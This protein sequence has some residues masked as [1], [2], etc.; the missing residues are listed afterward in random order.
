MR[1]GEKSPCDDVINDSGVGLSL[2]KS[3]A[4]NT[5][6]AAPKT[7]ARHRRKRGDTIRASDFVPPAG[8]LAS[9]A[10]ASV[11]P[12]ITRNSRAIGRTR[13]GTVTLASNSTHLSTASMASGSSKG[14]EDL[15]IKVREEMLKHKRRHKGWPTIKMKIDDEP[16]PKQRSDEEDD[17]LLLTGPWVEE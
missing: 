6:T 10:S 8:T 13:S 11:A 7:Q 5:Q 2:T 9:P 17:E 1:A 14:S 4:A 12:A 15:I 3:H 16:L